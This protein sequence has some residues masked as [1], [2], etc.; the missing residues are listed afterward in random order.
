MTNR[1]I[2]TKPLG[3]NDHN[4]KFVASPPEDVKITIMYSRTG[5]NKRAVI[6]VE[7][8]DIINLLIYLVLM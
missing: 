7:F 5:N 1:S 4:S 2:H 3:N 6:N 8:Q